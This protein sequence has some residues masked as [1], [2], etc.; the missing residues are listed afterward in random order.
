MANVDID[1]E[2]K[3]RI[4]EFK[5]DE[6]CINP[7]IVMIAKRGSGKSW[8]TREIIYRFSDIPAGVI[9]SQTEKDNPFYS[10]F[11]PDTF[12]YYAYDR[13]LIERILI[14]QKKINKKSREKE[15]EQKLMDPR[16]LLVMDDC[17]AS[18][19]EWSRDPLVADLLMNGRHRKITYILTMQFPLGITPE[20][21]ANFD[22]IFLLADDIISNLKRIYD[23]YAGIFKSFNEFR[24]VFS[25]LT[26]N[27]GAMVIINRGNRQNNL[28]D[29]IAFFKASNL[30]N[31]ELKFGCR[32]FRKYH[33][34]NYDKD[35]EEKHDDL[36]IGLNEVDKKTQQ[37][38]IK[39]VYN[40][41]QMYGSKSTY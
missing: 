34:K 40:K 19:G 32:Q 5:L 30:D 6:M 10:N 31:V 25:Q 22:Y 13:K 36:G 20:L 23:H 2:G 26:E 39:R 14:R 29:K 24:Q 21:R 37:I 18:K 7:S 3:M 15:L 28:T 11:F 4:K 38:N 41:K 27:F 16:L 12:I 1:M 17:L 33:E 9:I 35:W 8:I